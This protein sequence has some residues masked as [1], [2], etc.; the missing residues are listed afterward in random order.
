MVNNLLT[1]FGNNSVVNTT[2]SQLKDSIRNFMPLVFSIYTNYL[3]ASSSS[4]STNY[5]SSAKNRFILIIA[6]TVHF[7]EWKINSGV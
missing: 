5:N 2:L 3:T 7:I 1:D 4:E 6:I